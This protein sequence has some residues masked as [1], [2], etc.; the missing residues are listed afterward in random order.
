MKKISCFL[1]IVLVLLIFQSCKEEFQIKDSVTLR[2]GNVKETI[3][4]YVI[5]WE[6]SGDYLPSDPT[7]V[8]SYPWKGIIGSGS[9]YN[10]LYDYNSS[11]GWVLVYNTFTP[12]ASPYF[13]TMP[14]G[15]L[16]F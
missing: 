16:Y 1:T 8:V 9:N 11:D 14:P 13:A 5:D 3:P 10:M 6:T 7:Q 15:G 4:T 2:A 12:T